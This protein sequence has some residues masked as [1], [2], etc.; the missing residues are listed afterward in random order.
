MCKELG[1]LTH[2]YNNFKDTNA[3]V[4]IIVKQIKQTQGNQM[5]TYT[6]I[7]VDHQSQNQTSIMY[8]KLLEEI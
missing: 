6:Q 1:R 3:C 4:F 2:E 5:V 8:N 7:V